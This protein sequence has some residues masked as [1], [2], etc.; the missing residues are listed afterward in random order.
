MRVALGTVVLVGSLAAGAVP[1]GAQECCD[2]GKAAPWKG[3]NAGIRWEAAISPNRMRGSAS[4]Q[5]AARAIASAPEASLADRQ[6][7]AC[8]HAGGSLKDAWKAGLEPALARARREGKLL[9]LF[10][11]VGDLDLEG[12]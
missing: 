3:Y 1:A 4:A 2:Q 5:E 10:Q 9:L 7:L 11:L 8:L 12:C 6:R